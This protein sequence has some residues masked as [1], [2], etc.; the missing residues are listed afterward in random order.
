MKSNYKS[1]SWGPPPQCL[2]GKQA[3]EAVMERW[4]LR[5]RVAEKL[6]SGE[7][8]LLNGSGFWNFHL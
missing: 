4:T 5:Y 1:G 7:L 3:P 8:E 6:N 2:C